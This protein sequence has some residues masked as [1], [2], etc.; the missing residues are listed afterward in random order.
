MSVAS[1]LVPVRV[2]SFFFIHPTNKVCLICRKRETSSW[3]IS[4]S[5][6]FF[7]QF[8]LEEQSSCEIQ[9]IDISGCVKC[10]IAYYN[11]GGVGA[12]KNFKHLNLLGND[13]SIDFSNLREE[14]SVERLAMFYFLYILKNCI[15]LL[16]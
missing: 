15:C 14:F 7:R 5:A 3:K 16:A 2:H 4:Y 6:L 12:N 13:R 1:C 8:L 10:S 9:S 11:N